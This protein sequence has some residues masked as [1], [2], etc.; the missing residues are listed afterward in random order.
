MRK[1]HPFGFSFQLR[2][3]LRGAASR[4]G[5]KQP[6]DVERQERASII[7]S[8][9]ASA[10]AGAFTTVKI[11]EH[12]RTAASLIERFAGTCFRVSERE[13]GR[14]LIEVIR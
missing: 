11:S 14:N 1:R 7:C 9:R 10:H 3:I 5:R 6:R 13:D 4:A 12:T 2:Y 8:A